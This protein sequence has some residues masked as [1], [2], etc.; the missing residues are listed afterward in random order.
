VAARSRPALGTTFVS[1]VGDATVSTLRH[2]PFA[3]RSSGTGGKFAAI[4]PS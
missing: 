4:S 1:D 2:L 3:L